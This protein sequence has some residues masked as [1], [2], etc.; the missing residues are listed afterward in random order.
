MTTGV[1]RWVECQGLK[2]LV[3]RAT[4]VCSP[5]PPSRPAVSYP[6]SLAVSMKQQRLSLLSARCAWR[7][8][9]TRLSNRRSGQPACRPP[10]PRCLLSPPPRAQCWGWPSGRATGRDRHVRRLFC[11]F[12]SRWYLPL[13]KKNLCATLRLSE[14]FLNLT[15]ETVP[16]F[17]N[18]AN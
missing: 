7:W 17:V 15:L 8:A 4:R 10:V 12:T 16:V 14:V 6:A 1:G 3:N 9:N 5:L 2:S 11:Q 13:G 18:R